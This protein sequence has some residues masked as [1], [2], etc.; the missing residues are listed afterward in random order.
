MGGISGWRFA[1]I[2]SQNAFPLHPALTCVQSL[3]H[4]NLYIFTLHV[5]H[6]SGQV[7]TDDLMRLCLTCRLQASCH[8]CI[9]Y[10][11]T[12]MMMIYRTLER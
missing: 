2:L 11:Y 12:Y 4:A 9:K 6:V 5:V 10:K 3:L 8:S 7:T 1:Q